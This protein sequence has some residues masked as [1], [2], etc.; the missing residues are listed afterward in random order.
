MLDKPICKGNEC[1]MGDLL[2]S[3]Q[4]QVL[5]HLVHT[6]LDSLDWAHIN[7]VSHSL[8]ARSE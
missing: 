6:T 3:I 4:Q 7:L 2:G 5:N 8:E 1:M